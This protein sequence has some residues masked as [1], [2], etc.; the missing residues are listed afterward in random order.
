MD[1][2]ISLN[3]LKNALAIMKNY[4]DNCDD[5]IE[6]KLENHINDLIT[7]SDLNNLLKEIFGS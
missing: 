7:E 4:V 3:E 6:K 2:A 5:E 1:T